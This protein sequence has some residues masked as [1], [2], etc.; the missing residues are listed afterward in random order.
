G[1]VYQTNVPSP[2]ATFTF[3]DGT[4]SLKPV[5]VSGTMADP[6][7]YVTYVVDS[8]RPR[9][10]AIAFA[11]DANSDKTLNGSEL[12]TGAPVM[13]I[14]FTGVENGRAVTVINR[15]DMSTAGTGTVNAN[16]AA[17]TLSGLSLTPTS[18]TSVDLEVRVVDAA[19]NPNNPIGS[20]TVN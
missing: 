19:N 6:G 9:V 2:A 10:T 1:F 15:A 11:G 14:I 5:F 16:A 20:I 7:A 3:P 18:D 8:I 17:V 4:Y 12:P 13:N